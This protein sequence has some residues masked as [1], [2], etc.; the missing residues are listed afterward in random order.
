[1]YEAQESFPIGT[2]LWLKLDYHIVSDAV[3]GLSKSKTKQREQAKIQPA[4][5]HVPPPDALGHL[6]APE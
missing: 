1:M 6:A 2:C 3:Y 5:L 4:I